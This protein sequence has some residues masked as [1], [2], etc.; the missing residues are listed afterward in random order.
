M[1]HEVWA[2]FRL[3]KGASEQCWVKYDHQALPALPCLHWKDFL[4]P[5]DS[6]F[7]CLDIQE[8]QWEKMVAYAQALQFWAEKVDLSTEDKPCLLAGS[9]IQ[10]QEEM[11]CYLS[12]SDEDVFR[13]VAL[14]EEAPKEVTPQHTQPTPAGTPVKE[15]T[16]DMTMEPTVEKRPP[17][18]FLVWEEVLHPS[19]PIVAIGQIPPLSRA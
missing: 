10:L 11:K 15:A 13:G 9:T 14:P 5:P 4:L 3:P 8:I 12:F 1:A 17:N 7:A 6:I 18:K 16:M 2:S 19:R